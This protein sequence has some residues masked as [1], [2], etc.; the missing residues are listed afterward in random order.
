MPPKEPQSPS[1]AVDRANGKRFPTAATCRNSTAATNTGVAEKT[2]EA[3]SG[4]PI[5]PTASP[6]VT[7]IHDH[8]QARHI[9]QGAPMPQLV[10]PLPSSV[11]TKGS[12]FLAMVLAVAS[13]TYTISS[14]CLSSVSYEFLVRAAPSPAGAPA[15]PASTPSPTERHAPHGPQSA[16]ERVACAAYMITPTSTPPKMLPKVTGTRL[17]VMKLPQF[18]RATLMPAS[19]M[20]AA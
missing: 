13:P 1:A 2:N 17:A 16:L 3:N 8:K 11:L 12:H 14:Q 7:L 18:N 9:M 20:A 15:A 10:F 5:V 19:A 4:E 6:P